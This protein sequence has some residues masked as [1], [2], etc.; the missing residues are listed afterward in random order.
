VGVGGEGGV[1]PSIVYLET[2]FQRDYSI[3]INLGP[4]SQKVLERGW[5]P[6][7]VHRRAE[8]GGPELPINT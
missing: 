1:R 3:F 5:E 8:E 4:L 7:K 2:F 6:K